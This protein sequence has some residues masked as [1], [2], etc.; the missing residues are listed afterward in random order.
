MPEFIA[1]RVEGMRLNE[2]NRHTTLS[3]SS[4]TPQ[5]TQEILRP[6]PVLAKPNMS[7]FI[8]HLTELV[9]KEEE[10][11]KKEV[12]VMFKGSPEELEKKGLAI[13]NLVV[14]GKLDKKN[15]HLEDIKLSV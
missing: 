13:I 4:S 15:R 5:D 8:H 2:R 3:G 11:Y 12:R 10:I 14:T 1:K 7:K 9:S 6:P